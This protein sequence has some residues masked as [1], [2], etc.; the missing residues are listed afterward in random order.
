MGLKPESKWLIEKCKH[1][2]QRWHVYSPVGD[3]EDAVGF[4]WEFRTG[5]QALCFVREQLSARS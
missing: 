5:D 3:S 2:R 4:D 1:G